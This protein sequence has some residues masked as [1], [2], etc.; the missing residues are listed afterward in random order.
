MEQQQEWGEVK[1]EKEEAP[2]VEFEVEEEKKEEVKE[3]PK[4]E[5][6]EEPKQEPKKEEP[7]E[8]EGIDTKGA[9]KRIR[10]LVKQRKEKEEEVARLIRQNEELSNRVKKQEKDFYEIGKLNLTA[11]EKQIKD[12][13]DL[14]R[15]AYAT[16]HEEGDSA[17]ILKAQEALNEAQ[18]DLKTIQ[19]TKD[20]FKEPEVQ[21]QPLQ[22][23]QVQQPQ[24]QPDPKAQ[25]WAAQNEWFGQD[26]IMTASALAIDTELK[27]EGYDPTSSEFYEEINNRLQETFPHKFKVN[28][29]ETKEVRKQETSE[30]AQVV[31]GGTRS[32]PSSKNKVK[33]TKED[34]RLANKWNIPL[35]QYAQEKLKA[36][37]AEGEYTTINMQR[38]GKK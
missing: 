2:K 3:E 33:L 13:L 8:L 11:N 27:E 20:N 35:E 31:A 7:K 30:T 32:T 19:S 14:A 10:Q 16:A 29:E 37:S 26:R 5:I 9:Q 23:Q 17:K 38:G 36:T 25:D 21:Q 24:P 12:K 6:K 18:V 34:V 22:Q 15:T 4:Q 28:K 1:V